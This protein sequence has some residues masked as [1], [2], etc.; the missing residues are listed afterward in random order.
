MAAKDPERDAI[1]FRKLRKDRNLNCEEVALGVYTASG[2]TEKFLHVFVELKN[3]KHVAP[4]DYTS[5]EAE[6]SGYFLE[7]NEA[8]KKLETVE[9][10]PGELK[11]QGNCRE[12]KQEKVKSWSM[13][14]SVNFLIRNP[15][16]RYTRLRSPW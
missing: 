14:I 7:D 2:C 6:S 8:D 5:P 11:N 12:E 3:G 10:T 15:H 9:L 1:F 13:N 4:C 16:H